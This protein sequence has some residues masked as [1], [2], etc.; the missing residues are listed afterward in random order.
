[1]TY[2]IQHIPLGNSLPINNPHSVSVSLPSL[3]NV[4]DYEENKPELLNQLTSGYPRFFKNKLVQKLEEYVKNLHQ[5]DDE[6]VLFPITSPQAKTIIEYIFNERFSQLVT[7]FLCRPSVI[8]QNFWIALEMH[9]N[10]TS[11]LFTNS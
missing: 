4:I 6:K 11:M 7:L 5:I 8:A 9:S 2:K 10:I 3:Q 1:M